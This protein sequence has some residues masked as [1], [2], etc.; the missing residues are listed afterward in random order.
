MI[1]INSIFIILISLIALC[2]CLYKI[3][4]DRNMSLHELA[5]KDDNFIRNIL[6]S[7]YENN[8]SIYYLLLFIWLLFVIGVIGF[9]IGLLYIIIF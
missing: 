3:A 6:L 9:I 8:P 5:R 1:M 7:L 2:T 4:K